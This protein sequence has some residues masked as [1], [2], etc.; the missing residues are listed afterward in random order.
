MG[1]G[2]ETGGKLFIWEEQVLPQAGPPPH[3]HLAED[4][5]F[6]IIS[7]E[8]TFF[9]EHG[10]AEAGPGSLVQLAKDAVHTFKNTG[11]S[12]VLVLV[13]T[14]PA[15]FEHFFTAV[16]TPAVD[17]KAAPPVTPEPVE[18]A[19]AAAPLHNLEFELL[20]A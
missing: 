15:G 11:D 17:G 10:A 8:L 2:A 7:G 6:Y 5:L 12:E 13:M 20:G 14:A 19:L 3:R 18:R 16:G 4:E 1:S 9:S